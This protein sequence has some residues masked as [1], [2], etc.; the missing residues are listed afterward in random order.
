MNAFP[1]YRLF[2][3]GT[4]TPLLGCDEFTRKIDGLIWTDLQR[5]I[6]AFFMVQNVY[7]QMP[8]QNV[9]YS[10]LKLDDVPS[11]PPYE[12]IWFE[13]KN[14]IG[15][16]QAVFM[17]KDGT[18]HWAL[19]FMIRPCDS[20]SFFVLPVISGI[21]FD[22]EG[23]KHGDVRLAGPQ[24]LKDMVSDVVEGV[25]D[26]CSR[27]AAVALV[28]CMFS[29]CKNVNLVERLPKRHEQREAKRRGEQILKYHEIVIDPNRSYAT[30]ATSESTDNKPSRSL[31]IAR[32]HFAH[33]TEDRKLFGK[34]AGTF[35]VPAHVR[36]R[37]E[38]GVVAS[39][40]KVKAL[41]DVAL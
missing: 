4:I 9:D 14:E 11:I 31:H 13:W 23:I 12:S 30:N 26:S 39:T 20:I 34:Y 7:D 24:S 22:A 10:A 19:A 28:S 18:N 36:G 5:S 17:F 1:L 32:G 6:P 33:Y 16:D 29:H 2:R 21:E 40:Y 8:R 35:W 38:N 41:D 3:K 25:E 37:A 15:S 27:N